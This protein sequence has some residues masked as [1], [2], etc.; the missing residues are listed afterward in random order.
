MFSKGHGA[1]KIFLVP[2]LLGRRK[3]RDNKL[4]YRQDGRTHKNKGIV[5]DSAVEVAVAARTGDGSVSTQKTATPY[6]SMWN[7]NR[8]NERALARMRKQCMALDKVVNTVKEHNAAL[9]K[10]K[11][12]LESRIGTMAKN[13]SSLKQEIAREKV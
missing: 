4:S 3:A 12:V 9:E 8:K 13:Q 7:Q 1:G 10:E 6:K 2:P 11:A 5:Q